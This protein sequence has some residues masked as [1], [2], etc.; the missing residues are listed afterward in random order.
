MQLVSLFQFCRQTNWSSERLRNMSKVTQL[1]SGK[2]KIHTVAISSLLQS[3][4]DF[5]LFGDISDACHL[6]ANFFIKQIFFTEIFL[7]S[8]WLR[9]CFYTAIFTEAPIIE[10]CLQSQE[11]CLSIDW[12]LQ[13]IVFYPGCLPSFWLLSSLLSDVSFQLP[14]LYHL[15]CALCYIIERTEVIKLN[16]ITLQTNLLWVDSGPCVASMPFFLHWVEVDKIAIFVGQVWQF[17][18]SST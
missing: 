1:T 18:Y 3:K 10:W 13:P 6:N 9:L 4:G 7:M 5:L 14:S 16:Q 2:A 15:Q 8:R 17:L 11:H 12:W